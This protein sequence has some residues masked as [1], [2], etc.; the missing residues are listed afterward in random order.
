MEE[1]KEKKEEIKNKKKPT[2]AK[3]AETAPKETKK[4]KKAEID[5][6]KDILIKTMENYSKEKKDIPEAK[7]GEIN[8]E[9]INSPE[10]KENDKISSKIED[11]IK[12]IEHMQKIIDDVENHKSN[13]ENILEEKNPDTLK[14]NVEKEINAMNGLKNEI[15]KIIRDKHTT[16]WSGIDYGL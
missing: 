12:D 3:K 14:E 2:N 8:V 5:E 15:N 11:N 10:P 6:E 7:E 16:I 13:L 4:V 9:I 1:T